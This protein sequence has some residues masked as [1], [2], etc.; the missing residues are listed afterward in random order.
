MT[1][2]DIGTELNAWLDQHWD[3]Q[4]SLREWRELLVEGGW[5]APGWP[6]DCF[7]RDFTKEQIA[8][9]NRIFAERDIVPAATAGPGSLAAETI[10][11]MGTDVQKQRYLKPILTGEESWC[12]LFSEPGSG[13][14]LAGLAT[15]AELID[16]RWIINGQKVWNTSAHHADFGI[17]VARTN[18]DV[19]K[20]Q[21]ISY[22]LINM[23][24]HGY[25]SAA[26]AGLQHQAGAC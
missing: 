5:A 21:G 25:S 8:L 14:D 15:K 9:V 17:L 11:A 20:H 2:E 7:G 24:Q 23:R 1:S 19:P 26:G 6:S 18:F 3:A 22:F 16:G 4:L 12:Q 10:L 13:S